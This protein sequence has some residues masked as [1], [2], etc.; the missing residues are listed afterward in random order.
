[1]RVDGN[2]LGHDLVNQI[3]DELTIRNT[4]K[5]IAKRTKRYEWWKLPDSFLLAELDGDELVMPRGY[6]VQLKLLLR[7][8]GIRVQWVDRRYR[9]KG[10]PFKWA[11]PFTPR[12]HQPPAVKAMRKHQQG[13][14][15]APTGSGKSLTC[16]SFIKETRPRKA[17]ILVDKKD[18]L[19][20]WIKNFKDWLGEEAGKIGDGKFEYENRICVATVQTIWSYMKNGKLPE[21]FFEQYAVVIADECHHATAETWEQII[22][23]FNAQYRIGD[24]ATPD[25]LDDKFEFALA[26]L[27]EVFHMDDEDELVRLG[28]LVRPRVEVI[29]TDFTFTFWTDHESDSKG[30]CQVPGC[31]IR[32]RHGHRNNYHKLKEAIVYDYERNSVIAENIASVAGTGPHHQIVISDEIRHLEAIEQSVIATLVGIPMFT[33]T[34]KVTGKKRKELLEEIDRIDECIIF[35]TVAKEGLDIPQLDRVHLPFPAG[36]IKP[37]EQKIGRGTRISDNKDDSVIYDYLDW[38][39]K[40]LLAQFKKRRYGIYEKKNMEVVI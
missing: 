5:T 7:E 35:A 39:V 37:T 12:V 26:V 15:Q 14:Y 33:L 2:L 1:M 4:A 24:S 38:K 9:A 20:Q 27:G 18:L 17:I 32:K 29:K 16:I 28:V 34:G 3:L 10:P 13:M 21:G 30:N 36:N 11:K 23:A 8:K 31:K 6:A 40:K 25:K 19:N 22:G